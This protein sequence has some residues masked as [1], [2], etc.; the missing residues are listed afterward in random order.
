MSAFDTK[1]DFFQ[2]AQMVRTERRRVFPGKAKKF[3]TAVG[4]AGKARAYPLKQGS[5]L[6]RAQLG[7]E[8]VVRDEETA[9]EEEVPL[10]KSRM[11]PDPRF[12]KAG[13]RANPPGFAYLY[14]ATTPETALAEMRPWVGEAIS[15]ALFEIQRPIK[16]VVCRAGEEAAGERLFDEN[17]PA[18]KIASYV[19]NDISRAFA[20]PVNREDQDTAY[21]PTQILAE[22]FKA[23]GFD[24]VAYRSGLEQ[25]T[26]LALFDL[27]AAT[28]VH[29]FVYTTKKVRYDFEAVPNFGIYRRE[30][31]G[32]G[33]KYL[34]SIHT[35]S[36]H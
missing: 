18:D 19:W 35:E 36:P 13:G 33:G 17:P 1:Y 30:R 28:L 2:F 22:V 9:I 34:D 24:G 31:D 4:S 26:N 27:T 3:L 10:P 8:F 32:S 11:T 20:R 25:G 21:L 29:Q 7:S 15:L 12:I 5:R 14:L 23:N 6:Y 16:V